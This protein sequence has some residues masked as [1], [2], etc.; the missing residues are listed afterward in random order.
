MVYCVIIGNNNQ[1]ITQFC[2]VCT[3]SN[4]LQDFS[5]EGGILGKLRL[6]GTAVQ[7]TRKTNDKIKRVLILHHGQSYSTNL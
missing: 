5:R 1:H 3:S 2:C 6:T 4:A 7:P